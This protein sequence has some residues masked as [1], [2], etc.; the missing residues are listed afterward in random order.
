[1]QGVDL[2]FRRG[3]NALISGPTGS[4][5]STLFRAIAGIWPFGRGEIS[6]P[7]HGRVLFLP[8]KPYLPIGTLREVV[9]YPNL[10][11]AVDD[12]ILRE[13][14]EAVEITVAPACLA[15]WIAAIPTPPAPAWIRAVSPATRC[16]NSKRQSSA[17]PKGTGTQ[18]AWS[19]A[20]PSGIFQAN[21]AGTAR[22]AA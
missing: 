9:S 17:V 11:G 19:V 2:T 22:S 16:P 13:T 7:A 5:K 8:Q 1:M 12:A 4:G 18:A 21:D 15:S 10:P 3:D 6:M 14:L 20:N